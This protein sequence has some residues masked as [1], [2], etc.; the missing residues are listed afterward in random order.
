MRIGIDLGGTKIEGLLLTDAGDQAARIRVPTPQGQYDQT[1]QAV[2]DLVHELD[3]VARQ[4]ST[5]KPTIGVGIPGTISPHTGLVKN[6]NSVCLIG[7][8]LHIDLERAIGRPI[9]LANDANCFAVSEA[10]DGAAKGAHLVFGVI[11]GTGTGGGI[12]IDGKPLEG[13]NSVAGEWGHN[14]LP[15][16]QDDERPGPKCYCGKSGCIE[17]FLSGPGLKHDHFTH[18]GTPL[19]THDIIEKAAQ[20]EE[21]CIATLE[22]YE[23]RLARALA[24][25]INILD[26]DVIV[27]GGGLSNMGR[28][29]DTVPKLWGNWVFS[30]TVVTKLVPNLHGDSSGVRGAA[31]LWD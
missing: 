28:L 31:W 18:T 1:V 25:V 6:A 21:T 3:Q 23:H 9:K 13:L 29:C 17:T 15:W 4:A 27:L 22:R 8:P 24:T 10:V 2:T 30:D 20:G 5:T 26:P 16:A 7:N 14:P 12:C 11:L 19:E